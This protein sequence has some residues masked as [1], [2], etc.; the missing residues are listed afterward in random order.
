MKAQN[1]RYPEDSGDGR[2]ICVMSVSSGSDKDEEIGK[3]STLKLAP[4]I[5]MLVR[6]CR[7]M[8]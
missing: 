8:S 2:Q 4:G 3:G 5:G 7:E 6:A 1:S